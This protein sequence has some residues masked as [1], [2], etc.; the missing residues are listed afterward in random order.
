MNITTRDNYAV[1]RLFQIIV[2]VV[3][4]GHSRPSGRL[5]PLAVFAS[6]FNVRRE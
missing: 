4:K 5:L 1:L 6:L 2:L 3:F